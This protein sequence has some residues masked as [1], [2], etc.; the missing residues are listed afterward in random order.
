MRGAH[1]Q[2]K[3]FGTVDDDFGPFHQAD[4]VIYISIYTLKPKD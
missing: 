4:P 2:P 1:P 3:D